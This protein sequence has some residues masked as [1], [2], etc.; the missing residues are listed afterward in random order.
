M[1][2]FKLETELSGLLCAFEGQ[3]LEFRYKSP[4]PVLVTFKERERT[5]DVVCTAL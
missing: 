3:E 5:G 2:H 4:A 1:A